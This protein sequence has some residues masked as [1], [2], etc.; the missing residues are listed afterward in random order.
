MTNFIS[1]LVSYHC[2]RLLVIEVK[3]LR[4]IYRC[5]FSVY[6][7]LFLNALKTNEMRISDIDMLIMDEC[8]HTILRH[9]YNAIMEAYYTLCRQDSGAHLPQIIGLTAS[10]GVGACEDDPQ[11]HYVRICANL[12]CECITYVRRDENVRELNEFNPRPKRDQIVPVEPQNMEAEY[13]VEVMT[14]MKE[15]MMLDEMGDAAA[16]HE[17]G[18]Q[19]FENWIVQVI[20]VVIIVVV[21]VVASTV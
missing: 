1:N 11:V 21:T 6:L 18:T 15:L 10:L 8:H 9:P 19:Q 14:L 7:Q 3:R 16:K 12:D 13:A 5:I 17:L 20:I 4:V 2:L